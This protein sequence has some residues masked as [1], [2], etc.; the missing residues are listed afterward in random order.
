MWLLISWIFRRSGSTQFS[1]RDIVR[2]SIVRIQQ[3]VETE[4]RLFCL[5]KDFTVCYSDKQRTVNREDP[6]QTAYL[7]AV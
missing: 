6:D 7:E 4:I 5:L 1:K 3:I 2:L